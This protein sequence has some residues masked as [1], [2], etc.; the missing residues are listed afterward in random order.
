VK[1]VSKLV[2]LLLL[3]LVFWQHYHGKLSQSSL[4]F[5]SSSAISGIPCLHLMTC[6]T[7]KCLLT[8]LDYHSITSPIPRPTDTA[9]PTD[10]IATVTAFAMALVAA[11]AALLHIMIDINDKAIIVYPCLF[12][13]LQLP[14]TVDSYCYNCYCHSCVLLHLLLLLQVLVMLLLLL[15]H[16]LLTWY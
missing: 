1:V 8:H 16:Q 15:L 10:A 5:P 11:S 4:Y 14:V 12:F 9:A 2:L 3:M 7:L 13:L 6:Y